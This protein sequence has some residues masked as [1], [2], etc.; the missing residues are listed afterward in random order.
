MDFDPRRTLVLS[1]DFPLVSRFAESLMSSTLPSHMSSA[2]GSGLQ[3]L[4]GSTD[5]A[6]FLRTH[7][8]EQMLHVS[9]TSDR[10]SDLFSWQELNNVLSSGF[11]NVPRVRLVAKGVFMD[12]ALY[13]EERGERKW[14]DSRRV[15]DLMA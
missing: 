13:S 12:T 3:R 6:A 11:V 4:L 15:Q 5:T 7:L 2:C 10:W 14:P 1:W 8:G 9:N